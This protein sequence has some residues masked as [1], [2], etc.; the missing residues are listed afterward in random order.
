MYWAILAI[1]AGLARAN[2]QEDDTAGIFGSENEWKTGYV[3][4]GGDDDEMFYWLIRS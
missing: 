4:V 2:T 3:T 1:F